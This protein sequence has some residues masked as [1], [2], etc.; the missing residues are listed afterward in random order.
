VIGPCQELQLE[1]NV[2]KHTAV[3][4]SIVARLDREAAAAA[5][6]A[7]VAAKAAAAAEVEAPAAAVVEQVEEA[8]AAGRE[9]AA[10]A[11]AA[12]AAD[13]AADPAAAATA[14]AT[15]DGAK[16][17]ENSDEIMKADNNIVGWNAKEAEADAATSEEHMSTDIDTPLTAED[18]V[19]P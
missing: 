18:M 17:A 12:T 4:D 5:A 16:S 8:A 2:L 19:G 6:E 13:P 10:P 3:L 7:A 14:V 11:A 1:V 15:A 9:T